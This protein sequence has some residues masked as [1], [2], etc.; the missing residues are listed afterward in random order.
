MQMLKKKKKNLL[1]ALRN[2]NISIVQT[3]LLPKQCYI[4]RLGGLFLAQQNRFSGAPWAVGAGRLPAPLMSNAF[5]HWRLA[6][7]G[8]RQGAFLLGSASPPAR[9][10]V[11]CQ[12]CVLCGCP[13]G[14]SV[15]RAQEGCKEIIS[16]R[17][18]RV[19]KNT[20]RPPAEDQLGCH[21]FHLP[22]P[23]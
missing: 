9:A 18:R 22:P 6:T 2:R 14:E 16:V 17:G 10:S 11:L 3:C 4:F 12:R 1:F 13:G 19:W 23:N 15:G 5:F 8:Y 21:F 20:R 7:P